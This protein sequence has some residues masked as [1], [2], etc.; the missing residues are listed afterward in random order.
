M[1]IRRQIH[2]PP[3]ARRT[4]RIARPMIPPGVIGQWR[5]PNLLVDGDMEDVGV[6]AWT[7]YQAVLGKGTV[8]PAQGLRFLQITAAAGG[9]GRIPFG[10]QSIL[11]PGSTYRATGYMRSNG[12][13]T[14][15]LWLGGGNKW[16]GTTS[17]SWQ[18][19]D[20]TVV[21]GGS[22]NAGAYFNIDNPIGNEYIDV[23]DFYVSL[24]G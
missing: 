5:G 20:V 16:V 22:T 3:G 9:P 19:F 12:V 6:G 21:S 4:E 11:T 18:A 10:Y 1:T 17:T 2:L 15:K 8:M 24:E 7:L 13:E 23:D 14:P